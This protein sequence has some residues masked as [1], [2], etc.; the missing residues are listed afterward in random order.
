MYW[1]KRIFPPGENIDIPDWVKLSHLLALEPP[2]RAPSKAISAVLGR[3]VLVETCGIGCLKARVWHGI[4]V[5]CGEL[6]L[7]PELS[8]AKVD[9]TTIDS[10]FPQSLFPFNK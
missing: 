7:P 10:F 6:L 1:Y 2:A 5:G 3:V 9:V 4:C 8:L